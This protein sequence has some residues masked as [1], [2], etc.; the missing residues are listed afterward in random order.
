[1]IE[2]K[3]V[4]FLILTAFAI[5]IE[6]ETVAC[7]YKHFM[8]FIFLIRTEVPGKKERN[9]LSTEATGYGILYVRGEKQLVLVGGKRSEALR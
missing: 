4:V 1:L 3:Q 5:L 9:T 8:C 7:Y 6:R 2:D